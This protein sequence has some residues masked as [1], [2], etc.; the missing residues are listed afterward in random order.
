MGS[1]EKNCIESWKQIMPEFK[2]QLWNENVL[3]LKQYPFAWDAFQKGKYAFVSDVV[4]LHALFHEGGIYFDTDILTLKKFDPFLDQDFFVG[5]YRKGALN[6]AVVGSIAG[7]P[8]LRALLDYYQ[9][10]KFDF[11]NPLTIPDVFDQLVWN[12][13]LKSGTINPPK[14]F[15]PLPLEQKTGDY[16]KFLTTNSYCVHLWNH[17]WKDEFMVLKEYDF[18]ESLKMNF[19]HCREFPSIYFTKTHQTKYFKLFYLRFKNWIHQS[20]YGPSKSS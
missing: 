16:S 17:S 9:N 4:R 7:H 18:I 10:Q 6:A 13:P 3:D 5:E 15:Y 1:L 12:Y 19:K 20:I 14:Y 8:V 11:L 2:I